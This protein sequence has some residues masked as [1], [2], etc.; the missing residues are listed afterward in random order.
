MTSISSSNL[1]LDNTKPPVHAGGDVGGSKVH[2]GHSHSR[3]QSLPRNRHLDDILNINVGGKKY[4]VRRTTLLADQ[5]SRLAEWFRVGSM[6]H[7]PIDKGGNYYIDRDAKTFRHILEYLRLKKEKFVPLLALPSKPDE[8][9]KLVSETEALS[10]TELKEMAMDLLQKYQ[11]TEE[12]HYVTSYVQVA[13]S[14][15]ESWLFEH[16]QIGGRIGNKKVDAVLDDKLPS[17]QDEWDD[18]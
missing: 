14:E 9:A 6:K 2:D 11:R 16:E 13:L 1:A 8:L 5:K 17:G 4:T 12:Q 10:L 3:E 7:I 18:I 15:F